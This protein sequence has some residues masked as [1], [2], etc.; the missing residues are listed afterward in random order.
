MQNKYIDKPHPF[1]R[2]F[3]EV[4]KAF[5][6]TIAKKKFSVL[7]STTTHK[8]FQVCERVSHGVGSIIFLGFLTRLCFRKHCPYQ[9]NNDEKQI[10]ACPK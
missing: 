9:W 2:V 5:L 6:I 3:D 10:F 8:K 4:I 1:G 7:M